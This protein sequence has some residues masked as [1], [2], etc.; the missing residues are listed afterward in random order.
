MILYN[1][2]NH[3]GRRDV[4]KAASPINFVILLVIFKL[5]L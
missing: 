1:E 5:S 4:D 3:I 2:K